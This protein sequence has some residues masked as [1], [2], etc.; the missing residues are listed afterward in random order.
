MKLA[1]F[2]LLTRACAFGQAPAVPTPPP[3]EIPTIPG[4]VVMPPTPLPALTLPPYLMVGASCN[5]F[6]GCAGVISGLIPEQNVGPLGGMYTSLTA[7]INLTKIVDPVSGKSGYGLSPNMRLGQH[8]AFRFGSNIFAIGGDMGAAFSQTG[9]TPAGITIG[10][11]GS[12]TATYIHQFT[13]R[14]A[15]AFPIRMLY[16]A[17]AGPNNTGVWNPVGEAT[18]LFNLSGK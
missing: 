9:A 5:Q 12:F 4:P 6:T 16:V 8:K 2:S 18:L 7:D 14:F 17:K 10:L 1:L 11:A 15:V 13:Q 3:T